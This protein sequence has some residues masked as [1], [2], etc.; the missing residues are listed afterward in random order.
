MTTEIPPEFQQFVESMIGSGAFATEA[1]VVGEALR[2]LKDRQERLDRLRHEIQPAL[3]RLDRGEGIELD[4][5]SLD[6]FFEDIKARGDER[7][8]V[9]QE[10]Q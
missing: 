3:E 1:A 7:L 10:S 5:Q 6:A 4:D 9:T 2:L 8:E